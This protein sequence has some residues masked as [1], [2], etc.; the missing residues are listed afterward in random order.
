MITVKLRYVAFNH[1]QKVSEYGCTANEAFFIM[2]GHV[3]VCEP[4]SYREP[5]M[6]YGPGAFI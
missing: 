4:T 3:I 5:I 2:K 6:A 1:R